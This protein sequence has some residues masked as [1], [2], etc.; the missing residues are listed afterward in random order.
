MTLIDSIF[1]LACVLAFVRWGFATPV[2][3]AALAVAGVATV[4]L[5]GWRA[6]L[7]PAYAVGA[8]LLIA[9]FLPVGRLAQ[10]QQW[11]ALGGGLLLLAVSIAAC[12]ALPLRSFPPTA[13]PYS[14]GTLAVPAELIERF[15][16][17]SADPSAR[18]APQ[19]R[20][21][22]PSAAL[23]P[24]SWIGRQ[25]FPRDRDPGVEGATPSAVPARFPVL[26]YFSGWPSTEIQN[27]TLIRELVSRG[28]AVVSLIYPGR[29][30]SMSDADFARHVAYYRSPWNY[31]SE[32]GAKRMSELFSE[33]V[34]R[35]AEDA[36]AMLDVL[37]AVNDQGALPQFR[38]RLALDEAGVFGFSMGGGVAAQAGWLEP[39]IKA[40][41]NLDGWH[42]H[43]SL[44][45]GVPRPYLYMSE[46][47]SAPTPAELASSNPDARYA[48]ERRLTEYTNVPLVLERSGAIQATVAG[49]THLNFT[50]MNLHS[51]LRR[52]RQGGSIDRYRALEV[53]NAYV[54]S[55]FERELQGKREPLLDGDS[56]S[57]PEVK[58]KVWPKPGAV[59]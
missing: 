26:L 20:L 57:F 4:V 59:R 16:P 13:G 5:D 25:F 58:V 38:G 35:G 1:M 11:L 39:R 8:G 37:G 14:V 41:V 15:T 17:K 36:A 10:W 2:L 27:F 31:S 32:A 46:I 42:W 6:P 9:A 24:Q 21:W 30:P 33:R 45:Q 34:R 55:F 53:V 3:L 51:P 22:Y 40:V 47:L 43:E 54:C 48:A 28:F 23:P 44:Q 49:T 19:A 56:S 18:P 52:W 12:I 50:D 7:V 29:L